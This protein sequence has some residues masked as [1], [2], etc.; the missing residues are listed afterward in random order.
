MK[1]TI[2]WDPA[3]DPMVI[4]FTNELVLSRRTLELMHNP[5]PGPNGFEY[6]PAWEIQRCD[7]AAESI[8]PGIGEAVESLFA[9][10][11]CVMRIAAEAFKKA[12]ETTDV[13]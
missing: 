6:P 7:S 9:Q 5:S 1:L 10:V 8:M 12:E 2:R 13:E 11:D 4:S 3:D